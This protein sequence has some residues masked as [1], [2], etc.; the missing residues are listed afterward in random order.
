[1]LE[2]MLIGGGGGLEAVEDLGFGDSCV[3]VVAEVD[4]LAA[5]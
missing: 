3:L 1:M 5:V 4:G 2:F